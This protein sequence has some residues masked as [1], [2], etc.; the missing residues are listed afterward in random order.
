VKDV[1]DE[2]TYRNARPHIERTLAGSNSVF[3]HTIYDRSGRACHF[4][5]TYV[6]HRQRGQVV[7][8]VALEHDIT[9]LESA[10]VRVRESEARYRQL[11]ES[12]PYC[13]HE[14]DPDGVLR[15]V[16]SAGVRMM[17]K[18][19]DTE[20]IGSNFLH[21]AAPEDVDALRAHIEAAMHG[22]GDELEY[23]TGDG[24]TFA[25]SLTPLF[26]AHN[27][28]HGLMGIVRDITEQKRVAARRQEAEE[29]GRRHLANLQALS[30]RLES[31][32]EE[33]RKHISR[34]IHDEL[35]QLLTGL[36]MELAGLEKQVVAL[37]PETRGCLEER[38]IEAGDL[39]DRTIRSVREIAMRIRPSVLDELGLIAALKHECT[40]FREH[41]SIDCSFTTA[42]EIPDLDDDVATAL[43]RLCQEFLTN[44]ARHAG[45]QRA[46]V[47]LSYEADQLVLTVTDDGIGIP[48]NAEVV[49]GHLGLVG[50]RERVH[51]LH[52]SLQL[53][54]SPGG[55]TVV[56][57]RVPLNTTLPTEHEDTDR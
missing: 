57:V 20:L 34:E 43:F 30:A 31:I 42:G 9:E 21:C 1:L 40:R 36:K 53:D 29:E 6:P 49:S 28:V 23:L 13:I 11:V 10:T 52:G 5:A 33:E 15:S 41:S 4:L 22:R 32:R 37:P 47:G 8:Y 51:N 16:N 50:A 38:V 17:G 54:G 25:S 7:G 2:A 45:G 35:G 44:I 55:G 39:A 12:S 48:D 18:T 56:T 3:Q 46:A 27:R 24:H 26:D 14:I 19:R